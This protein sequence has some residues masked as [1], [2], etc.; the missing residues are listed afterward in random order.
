MISLH[1]PFL[2]VLFLWLWAAAPLRAGFLFTAEVG[3]SSGP[4][5]LPG[6]G[7]AADVNVYLA[8]EA[9]GTTLASEQLF[10]VG[11]RLSFDGVVAA[12]LAPGDVSGAPAFDV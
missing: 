4:V 9:G 2:V 6:V 1:R 5:T 10:S 7:S 3:G 8:E 12:V 11:L